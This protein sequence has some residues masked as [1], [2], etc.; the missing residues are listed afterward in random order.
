MFGIAE[1]DKYIDFLYNRGVQSSDIVLSQ[2]ER[3]NDA[4]QLF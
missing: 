2:S 4:C 1:K 3:M